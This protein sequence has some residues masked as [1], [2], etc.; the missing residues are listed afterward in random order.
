[1]EPPKL[2]R[3]SNP[4]AENPDA[5]TASYKEQFHQSCTCLLYNS[6]YGELL[7]LT[8]YTCAHRHLPC[9]CKLSAKQALMG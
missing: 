9:L 3:L 8:R 6:S 7:P 5:P 1:M 2:L 4:S